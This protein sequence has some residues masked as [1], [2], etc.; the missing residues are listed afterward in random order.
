[1]LSQ[2]ASAVNNTISSVVDT[3]SQ[4]ISMVNSTLSQDISTL[5]SRTEEINSTLNVLSQDIVIVNSRAEQMNASLNML[6]SQLLQDISA[7]NYRVEQVNSSVDTLSQ[8]V[9]QDFDDRVEQVNVSLSQLLDD[10]WNETRQIRSGLTA[11]GFPT[12]PASSC[13]DIYPYLPYGYYWVVAANGSSVEVFCDMSLT[14]GGVTGGWQRVVE[15][16]YS[17]DQCPRGFTERIDPNLRTCV[18]NTSMTGC[19]SVEFPAI[20]VNYSSVCGKVI[21]YQLGTPEAFS[22]IHISQNLTITSQYLDGI[23]L[24]HGDPMEHIWSF[25]VGMSMND[26]DTSGCPCVSNGTALEVDFIGSDYFCDSAAP[27]LS[28]ETFFGDDPLF[29][30]KG[31]VLPNECCSFN[32]PPWFYKQLL[33]STTDDIEM[34]VCSDEPQNGEDTPIEIV[35]IYV[36]SDN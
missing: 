23:S 29:D 28:P 25:A 20:S 35:E 10:V 24:T 9:L 3:V 6:S 27:D 34:R 26:T 17:K 18:R 12:F 30:G 13:A 32:S 21:A 11:L 36:R 2:E 33:Q 16:D 19:T 7:V 4:Y 14:C 22:P 31:C 8:R 5:N 15:L 1:M